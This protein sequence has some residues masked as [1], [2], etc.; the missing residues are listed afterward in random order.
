MK[1]IIRDKKSKE[2]ISEVNTVEE[3]YAVIKDLEDE[4]YEIYD[5]ASD[6]IIF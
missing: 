3:A 1:Y 2:K 4:E 6:L 5:T